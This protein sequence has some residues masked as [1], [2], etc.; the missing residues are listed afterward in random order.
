MG[1]WGLD[2]T[3]Y[4]QF[5]DR[6]VMAQDTDGNVKKLKAKMN[7]WLFDTIGSFQ[8]GP[9][10]LEVRGIYSPGNKARDNLSKR[11]RYFEPLDMDTSYYNSWS[12]IFAL[13]IDYTSGCSGGTQGMCTNVGYDRYGR[14]NLGVRATYALTPALSVWGV[15]SPMW[16][17]E[18]VDVNTNAGR[19]AIT[20]GSDKS[21]NSFV[22][23]Q[24]QYLGTELY[25]GT[26]W[27]FAPNTALDL[28]G[29]WLSAGKALDHS[30]LINGVVT[31]RKAE[32]AYIATARVRLSF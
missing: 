1:P 13:G 11:I 32:D 21:T 27:K 26:T 7:S 9:L 23:G 22:E 25:V 15:V 6:D 31:R 24:E 20:L 29:S 28:G 16:T 17:A 4:Y 30:E 18:K 8:T 12:S 2:P 3:F 14:A 10:L 19:G 5:G